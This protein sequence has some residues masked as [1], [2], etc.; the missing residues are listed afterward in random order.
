[1]EENRRVKLTK[2][3]I[4]DAFLELLEKIPLEKISVTEICGKADVNRST[5]YAYYNDVTELLH[6]IENDVL[7]QIPV[8][9][10]LP[11]MDADN[12]EFLKLLEIFFGYVKQNERLF[13]TLIVQSDS[14][15]FNR[16]LVETIMSN[17][18]KNETD[19]N[20]LLIDYG[21]IYAIN[22]VIG[23][24]REW[25]SSKFSVSPKTF[26][27]IVLEMSL[28]ANDLKNNDVEIE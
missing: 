27:K 6:E 25:I 9:K 2:A 11:A 14:S 18:P 23:L 17:Y 21:Y 3:M 24:L 4:K 8:S 26:A 28:R 22:G 7:S 19:K 12:D 20:R 13:K 1:M 16:R 5:F 10:D 15:D